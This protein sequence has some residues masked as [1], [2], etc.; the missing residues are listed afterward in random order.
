MCPSYS[1]VNHKNDIISTIF[2][3]VFLC[4]IIF[5]LFMFSV[6]FIYSSLNIRIIEN[7]FIGKKY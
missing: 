5:I 1:L 6:H 2:I 4:Y 3:I 7:K